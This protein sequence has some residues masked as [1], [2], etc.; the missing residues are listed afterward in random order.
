MVALPRSFNLPS[1]R[2][3]TLLPFEIYL[4]KNTFI[5]AKAFS[6][7]RY[8]ALNQGDDRLP[9]TNALSRLLTF[10]FLPVRSNGFISLQT[11]KIRQQTKRFFL[12][13]SPQESS[14]EKKIFIP[15]DRVPAEGESNPLCGKSVPHRCF[16]KR[17]KSKPRGRI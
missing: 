10:E 17:S 12:S 6:N 3:E 5:P 11:A 7:K 9:V 8:I 2:L 13:R 4:H 16:R 1:K 14:L 15:S